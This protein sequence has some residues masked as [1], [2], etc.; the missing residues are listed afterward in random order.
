M[1]QVIDWNSVL[2]VNVLL[3]LKSVVASVVKRNHEPF[4]LGACQSEV[5]RAFID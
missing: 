4:S 3:S 5:F 2:Q 1:S